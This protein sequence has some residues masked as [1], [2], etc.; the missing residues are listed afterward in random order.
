M[1]EVP[2][3]KTK[4][5]ATAAVHGVLINNT[6]FH[7]TSKIKFVLMEQFAAKAEKYIMQEENIETRKNIAKKKVNE[8]GEPSQQDEKRNNENCWS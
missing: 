2:G 5:T 7:S 8:K 3:V 4:V 6:F 1:F